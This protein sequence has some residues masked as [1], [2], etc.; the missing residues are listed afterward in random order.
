MT[1]DS[2]LWFPI[3]DLRPL[4][5][6]ATTVATHPHHIG[7]PALRLCSQGPWCS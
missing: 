2:D 5:L 4:A 1:T 6:H 3:R 7:G